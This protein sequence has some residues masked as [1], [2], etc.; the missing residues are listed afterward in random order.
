M[1]TGTTIVRRRG[2]AAWVEPQELAIWMVEGRAPLIIDV[3]EADRFVEGHIPGAIHRP[4]SN[5]AALV[6]TLPQQGHVLLVCNDGAMSAVV[7]R[8]LD[9]CGFTKVAF[10]S[11]GLEAWREAGYEIVNEKPQASAEPAP[12]STTPELQ[13]SPQGWSLVPLLRAINHRV[14]YAAMLGTAAVVVLTLMWVH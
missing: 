4:D 2:T 14:F 7:A 9:Y 13:P 3:R 5:A 12:P 1:Q 11:G 10:L 8:M 6:K